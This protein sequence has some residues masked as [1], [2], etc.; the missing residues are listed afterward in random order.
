MFLIHNRTLKTEQNNS[1][2]TLCFNREPLTDFQIGV[3]KIMSHKNKKSLV[4]QV[5]EQFD[6]MLA[7]GE[8]KHQDKINHNTEN[9]IYSWSTYGSYLKHANYFT[10]YCKETHGCR[11]LEECR[12]YID[13]WVQLR[14]NQK[15]SA[16]TIKLETASLAKLYGCNA[17]KFITTP[18]RHRADIQ[19]SRGKKVRDMHFSEANHK[20]LVEFCKST[21]LRR[22]E[23]RALTGDKLIEKNDIYYIIVNRGSK[24]GR[25]RESEVIGDIENV[26]KLMN[27]A[28]SGKVF[29]R[30]PSGADIHGYRS[31]YATAIYEKYARNIQEIPYD[32]YHKGLNVKYQSQVYHCRG[33]RMGVKLDK[34]AMLKASRALGHNRISVIGAHYLRF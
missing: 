6:G 21:G 10:S 5:Q 15:L 13:E 1:G 18:S 11:T 12:Q 32:R 4:R 9:K 29:D 23:L 14:I 16:Y 20:E 34:V 17:T 3:N 19:R 22:A 27:K 24:G 33:D 7:I 25:Y 28:G 31:M 30:V 2:Y 26:K 8:S